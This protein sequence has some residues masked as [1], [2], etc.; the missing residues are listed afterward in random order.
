MTRQVQLSD[1]AYRLLATEKRAGESFSDAV[2]RLMATRKD[3]WQ[4]VGRHASKASLAER[5]EWAQDAKG[6]VL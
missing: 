5:L 6:P 3:P 1:K 2:V 4:F